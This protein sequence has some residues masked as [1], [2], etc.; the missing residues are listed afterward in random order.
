MIFCL[1]VGRQYE[2]DYQI[3]LV[4]LSVE[5]RCHVDRHDGPKYIIVRP[6][7]GQVTEQWEEF[8]QPMGSWGAV[9]DSAKIK[10]AFLR[11]VEAAVESVQFPAGWSPDSQMGIVDLNHYL[12]YKTPTRPAAIYKPI[13]VRKNGPAIMLGLQYNENYSQT[14]DEEAR[15]KLN[16]SSDFV[17]VD[18]APSIRILKR[19]EYF[20]VR[21][22]AETRDDWRFSFL[23]HVFESDDIPLHVVCSKTD[24]GLSSHLWRMSC[25]CME[26]A[27]LQVT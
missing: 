24:V 15:A 13:Y 22:L 7:N 4:E 3:E 19:S 8:L 5:G 20:S 6:A 18:L 14:E 23:R 21:S 16:H 17:S 1:Q 25:S 12:I 9:L 10:T 27:L 26:A 11:A 2:F